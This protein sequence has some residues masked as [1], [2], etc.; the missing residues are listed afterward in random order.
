MY[1]EWA[2]QIGNIW[3][4]RNAISKNTVHL[5]AEEKKERFSLLVARCGVRS[6]VLRESH[7]ISEVTCKKCK[8]NYISRLN[9][10]TR[11]EEE[12]ICF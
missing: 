12:N 10:F 4:I 8:E 6:K 1:S 9:V 3:H 2:E 7:D 5:F 11:K